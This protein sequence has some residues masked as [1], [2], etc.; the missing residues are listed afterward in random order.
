MHILVK[1]AINYNFIPFQVMLDGEQN[2]DQHV[3][4]II[5][6]LDD[7]VILH[8]VVPVNACLSTSNVILQYHQEH[9]NP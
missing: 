1:Y 7:D 6:S 9:E 2:K 8:F 5:I 3:N 4:G